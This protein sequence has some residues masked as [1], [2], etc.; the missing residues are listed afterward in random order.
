MLLQKSSIGMCTLSSM[1]RVIGLYP[2]GLGFESLS[3]YS[4][5]RMMENFCGLVA[6]D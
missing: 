1:V 2:I 3:V 5:C 4:S 6:D